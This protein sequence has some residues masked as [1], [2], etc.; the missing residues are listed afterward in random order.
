[1]ALIIATDMVEAIKY[2][3]RIFGVN[4]EGPAEVYCEKNS[5]VINSSVLA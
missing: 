4:L 2:K 5:V 3:L 1:M